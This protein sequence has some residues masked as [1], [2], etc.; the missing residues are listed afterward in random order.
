MATSFVFSL[1]DR[2]IAR[3]ECAR[4]VTL[5]LCHRIPYELSLLGTSVTTAPD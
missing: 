2:R 3:P 1:A 4:D 5:E